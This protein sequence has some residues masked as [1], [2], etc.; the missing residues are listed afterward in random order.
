MST[1]F[2]FNKTMSKAASRVA[3]KSGLLPRPRKIFKQP[4]QHEKCVKQADTGYA[5][6]ILHPK[7]IT[8]DYVSPKVFTPEQ[9]LKKSAREPSKAYTE[10][11]FAQLPQA[12]QDKIRNAQLRRKYLKE[13][14]STEVAR[15]AKVSKIEAEARLEQ[16]AHKALKSQ[17]K[18][19]DAEFFTVPT[20][21]SYL[22]GPLIKP[23][24]EEEKEQLALKRESNRLQKKLDIDMD[25]AH[26][27]LALYNSSSKFAITEEKL[28]QL[29][30][31]AF[32]TSAVDSQRELYSKSQWTEI[33]SA[34][35]DNK[36]MDTIL[37]NVNDGPGFVQVEDSLTGFNNDIKELADQIQHERNEKK[38]ASAKE[39]ASQFGELKNQLNGQE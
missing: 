27:L 16:D 7:S 38:I 9:R 22:N 34:S 17:H 13:S 5:E 12:Q 30:N 37:D 35:F 8:R 4:F 39:K 25:L 21:E 10:Q 19:S 28:E 20:V 31:D 36:L 15:L 33:D 2:S 24:T 29:V 6:G 26:K 23:R 1:S 32:S 3:V 11:E 18:Q 14:Y